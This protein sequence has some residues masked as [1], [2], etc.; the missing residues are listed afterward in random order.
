MV[1]LS[2]PTGNSFVREAALSLEDS[3]VLGEFHTSIA[4]CGGNIFE[5]LSRLPGLGQIS[6]RS[7]QARLRPKLKLHPLREAFRLALAR[8]GPNASAVW[9]N[10]FCGIDAIYSSLDHAVSRSVGS[11]KFRAVY[12]YEDGAL[13]TF[14]AAKACGLKRIYDLPIAHWKAARRLLAE[15]AER[16][17]EWAC[18]LDGLRD[19]K[20]KLQRKDEEL[21]LADTVVVPS[22]F[23]RDS[24]PQDVLEQKHVEVVPFGSPEVME[25]T[26]VVRGAGPLK[27]LFV[28]S[29]TQRKGLGDLFSAMRMLDS[30]KFELHVLGSPVA[31]MDFYRSQFAG[32]IHHSARS[33]FEVLEL[34]RTCDIFVLTS[35]VEGR[36][37]VQQE[38][39]SCGLPIIVTKN[40]GAEDL[41][42]D[43]KAGF[44]VPIRSPEA[45]AEKLEILN[46]DRGLLA[47]MGNA[48]KEKASQ[49]TWATYRAKISE[50]VESLLSAA[51]L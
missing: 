30:K 22:N 13:E 29:M 28:G 19:Q 9:G 49:L 1:L 27:V 3:G 46:R 8:L 5:K 12:C 2:H 4:S 47:S 7:L 25:H 15:E 44:L 26:R 40:A 50:T 33:N 51:L 14:R 34:M 32:F 6:R 10:G 18:T 17:P 38:A 43:G 37:L 39:M 48:A 21:F 35:I 20:E 45:I 16:L 23:V 36:A 31:S 41:V 42:E 11:G 24:L